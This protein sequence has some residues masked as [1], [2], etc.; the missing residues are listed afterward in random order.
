MPLMAAVLQDKFRGTHLR[1]DRS[2][3]AYTAIDFGSNKPSF[4]VSNL[5]FSYLKRGS[6]IPLEIALNR[7]YWRFQQVMRRGQREG[8]FPCRKTLQF[9][10]NF[11][12]FS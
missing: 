10:D 11:H 9:S 4:W 6:A 2:N 3:P 7:L 5:N 12:I 1:S 8:I